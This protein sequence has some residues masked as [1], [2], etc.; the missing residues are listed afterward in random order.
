MK[1]V[2]CAKYHQSRVFVEI[3]KFNGSVED[4]K[5]EMTEKLEVYCPWHHCEVIKES[6]S[7]DVDYIWYSDVLWQQLEHCEAMLNNR[8]A[9][10]SMD[11]WNEDFEVQDK[12]ELIHNKLKYFYSISKSFILTLQP[13]PETIWLEG[14]DGKIY[15]VPIDEL[16]QKLTEEHD[17]WYEQVGRKRLEKSMKQ[18][19]RGVRRKNIWSR[20]WNG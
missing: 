17:K 10:D 1:L 20:I 15:E 19:K 11:I 5:R 7:F 13:P 9:V 6:M 14:D 16:K 3:G 12:N 4:L 18:L 8:D 2:Y